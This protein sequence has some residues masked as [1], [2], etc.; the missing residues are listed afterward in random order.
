V[1]LDDERDASAS[2]NQ[3]D[4]IAIDDALESLAEIDANQARIVELRY[5]TGMTIE[6][7]AEILGLSSATVK[8][9]WALA[10]A[11]LHRELIV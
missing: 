5:F 4:I 2:S 9:E 6:E 8:R 10:R 7:T 11:F 3:I 1:S